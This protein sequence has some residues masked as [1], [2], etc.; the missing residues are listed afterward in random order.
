MRR[1]SSVNW[2]MKTDWDVIVIGAGLAGLTAGATAANAGADTIVLEAHQTGGRARTVARGAYVFNMGAHALYVGG[3]GTKILRS[4]GVEPDGAPSPFPRYKLVK[5]GELHLMPSGLASLMRTRAMG[6]TS[7]AQFGKLLGLLPA[8]RPAKLSGTTVDE[9]MADHNLRPDVEAIVMALIRL[10]TYTADTAEF[11]ADAAIRQLQIGARPGVLYL[12]GGWAQLFA[13]LARHVPV[14]TGCQVSAL[15]PDGQ[16]VL[17]RT[18]DAVLRARRIIVAPGSPTA[19][20][21]LLP[22]DPAWP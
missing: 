11:S 3:P 8:I 22:E 21:A 19:T 10:S 1:A 20:R 15:E 14:Q 7:K 6:A 13:G 5:D 17:V 12:H 9:W 18:S 16:A 2:N 4:L